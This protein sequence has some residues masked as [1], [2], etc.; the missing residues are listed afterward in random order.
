M[1]T[2]VAAS[3]MNV[4]VGSVELREIELYLKGR[5]DSYVLG[6]AERANMIFEARK[7]IPKISL[8]DLD[9]PTQSLVSQGAKYLNLDGFGIEKMLDIALTIAVMSRTNR[10]VPN[11][12]DIAEAF[13]YVHKAGPE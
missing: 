9:V 2:A 5:T 8:D 11:N 1:K 13:Q 10:H 4:H 7:A 3:V 6:A 12:V